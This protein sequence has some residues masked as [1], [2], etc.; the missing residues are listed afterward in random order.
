MRTTSI[1]N[2]MFYGA[3]PEVFK[4]AKDLR[5]TETEAERLLWNQ[6]N[7]NQ[8]LG[9]QFRRQHPINKFIADFYCHKTKLVIEVDGGIHEFRKNKEY[10]L[11]RTKL[12]AQF[13]ITVI[14]FTNDQ[15]IDDIKIAVNKIKEISHKLL[16]EAPKS[17][18]RGI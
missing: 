15:I 4:K 1:E 13:G 6:L 14:R 7:R 5:K 2:S 10:D 9:L 18:F 17:P 11:E 8:I 16:I 12:L 3:T